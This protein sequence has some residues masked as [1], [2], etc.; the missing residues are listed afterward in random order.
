MNYYR[1]EY[2]SKLK[3]AEE[4]VKVIRNN[5]WIAYGEFAAFTPKLDRALAERKDELNSVHILA[6]GL[7]DK[8]E[9]I[10]SDPHGEVFDINDRFPFYKDKCFTLPVNFGEINRRADVAFLAVRPMDDNG[11][12]NLSLSQLPADNCDYIIAEINYSPVSYTHLDVYK[13]QGKGT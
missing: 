3:T 11:F 12:F 9:V 8:C 5:D 4:A 1:N 2:T 10:S 13:R 6:C 7:G